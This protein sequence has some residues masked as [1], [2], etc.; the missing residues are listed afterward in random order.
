[1]PKAITKKGKDLIPSP[2]PVVKTSRDGARL[3][4]FL[5]L[6]GYFFS[7]FFSGILSAGAASFIGSAAFVSLA[8]AAASGAGAAGAGAGGG[9]GGAGS[10]FLPHPAKLTVKAK[11]VTADNET[12]FFP[13]LSSPPFPS[14]I[15][16]KPFL[17]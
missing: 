8:G 17:D 7:S 14:H 10:S 5:F 11:S 13:I 16:G 2:F 6:L 1:V 3:T 12:I 4:R 9:G 15:N